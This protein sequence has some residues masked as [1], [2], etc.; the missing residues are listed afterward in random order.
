VVVNGR[1]LAHVHTLQSLQRRWHHD[2]SPHPTSP[3]SIDRDGK[4]LFFQPQQSHR[5][6]QFL[7]QAAIVMSIGIRTLSVPR[8]IDSLIV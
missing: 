4:D 6:C 3:F 5:G 1:R 2:D 8:A 7:L